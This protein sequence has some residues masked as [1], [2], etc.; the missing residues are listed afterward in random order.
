ME[1]GN[2]LLAVL[3]PDT[4]VVGNQG[5]LMDVVTVALEGKLRQGMALGTVIGRDFSVAAGGGTS[6]ARAVGIAPATGA[7]KPQPLKL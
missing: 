1:I 4:E 7:H 2:A 6:L 5:A 3:G